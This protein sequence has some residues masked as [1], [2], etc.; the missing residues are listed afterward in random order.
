MRMSVTDPAGWKRI[1]D[2][3]A[4]SGD[5]LDILVNAAGAYRRGTLDTETSESHAL[6]FEVN[7]MGPVLGVRALRPLL[8]RSPAALV[9]SV[10]SGAALFGF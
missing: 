1:A 9:V 6:S 3:D 5:R 7:Q 8:E 4:Q 10:Y 2:C